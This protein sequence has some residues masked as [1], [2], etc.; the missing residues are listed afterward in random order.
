[1]NPL[2]PEAWKA[3]LALWT[4]VVFVVLFAVLA[5]IRLGTVG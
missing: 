5:E 1:M 4:A 2:A 3:D